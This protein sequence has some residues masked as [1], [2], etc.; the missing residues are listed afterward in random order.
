MIEVKIG[1]VY[2]FRYPEHLCLFPEYN[3]HRGSF[4]TVVKEYDP[5]AEH[6]ERAFEVEALCDG[7]RGAAWR[8]ELEATDWHPELKAIS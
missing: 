6:T 8:S 2:V 4:V 5:Q 1:E 3:K 7:W